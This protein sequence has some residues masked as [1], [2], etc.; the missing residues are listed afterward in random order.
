MLL[1]WQIDV[2]SSGASLPLHRVNNDE[3][4]ANE[5]FCVDA[6][7]HV[8]VCVCLMAVSNASHTCMSMH[9]NMC[10][11]VRVSG[12]MVDQEEALEIIFLHH[13]Y[14]RIY[15]LVFIYQ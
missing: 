14:L 11:C 1:L 12:G 3:R 6:C 8:C 5:G 4:T 9:D 15:F 13:L 2:K 10:E 7:V